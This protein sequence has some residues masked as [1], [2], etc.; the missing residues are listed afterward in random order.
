MGFGYG[1]GDIV[2]SPASNAIAVD[3]G[4]K[5]TM[6]VGNGKDKRQAGIEESSKENH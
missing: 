6:V 4:R 5:R 2:R 3:G 1:M